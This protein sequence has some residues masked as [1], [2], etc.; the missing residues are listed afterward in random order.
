MTLSKL[1]KKKAR[2]AL[3]TT[4][5]DLVRTDSMNPIA[6][7]RAVMMRHHGIQTLLDVGAN[8]GQYASEIREWG[9]ENRILSFEPTSTAFKALSQKASGDAQWQVFNFA[10]GAEDGSAEINVASNWGASSSLLPMLDAHKDCAPDTKYVATEHVAVKTLDHAVANLIAP[11]EVLML[12]MDVQGFEHFVLRG[13]TSILPQVRLIE[14][15]LSFVPLYDGQL[16]FR[17]MLEYMD[18]LGFA[19]V[20]F[21]P[22][23]P[24]P[25]TGHALCVDGVFARVEHTQPA[26]ASLASASA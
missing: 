3:R 8:M 9:F 13:A 26:E 22:I 25:V 14:C 12:K 5:F 6:S 15:E 17:P 19:P 2:A 7:R 4:G 1:L 21:N 16:L 10:V 20:T 23:F 24:H 11:N 18:R